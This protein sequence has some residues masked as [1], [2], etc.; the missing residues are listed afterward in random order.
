MR[1]DIVSWRSRLLF[2]CVD[3][4]PLSLVGHGARI[5]GVKAVEVFSGASRTM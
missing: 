5:Y 3:I 2:S 1:S 4:P